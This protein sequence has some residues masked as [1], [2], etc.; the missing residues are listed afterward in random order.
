MSPSAQADGRRG[1]EA[2]VTPP[3]L[4]DMAGCVHL[5]RVLWQYGFSPRYLPRVAFLAIRSLPGIP[6]RFLDRCLSWR[7]V[8]QTHLEKA[9][10][11]V[12][13]HWRSGTTHLHNLLG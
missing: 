5:A 8:R 7:A 2:R 3:H 9:P 12:I 4:L 1:D 13:G 6:F 10:V 11:F